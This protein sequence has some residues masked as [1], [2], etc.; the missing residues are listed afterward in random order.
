MP[1]PPNPPASH[2]A[3]AGAV[4]RVVRAPADLGRHPCRARGASRRV[5]RQRSGRRKLWRKI[6]VN[7]APG[8]PLRAS[9]NATHD[10]SGAHPSRPPTTLQWL[11]RG[12]HPSVAVS[13]E[14]R[15]QNERTLVH[16]ERVQVHLLSFLQRA[17]RTQ[18]VPPRIKR[19]PGGRAGRTLGGMVAIVLASAGVAKAGLA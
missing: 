16:E 12:T 11:L 7:D 15:K 3:S 13:V 8:K 6:A 17:G 2:G 19:A 14:P 5:L 1:L 4:R 9:A 10:Q 18:S